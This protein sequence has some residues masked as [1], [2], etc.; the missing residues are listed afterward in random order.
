MSRFSRVPTAKCRFCEKAIATKAAAFERSLRCR[1]FGGVLNG[2]NLSLDSCG[3]VPVEP[4][5]QVILS[6]N[7][8]ISF[9]GFPP[10][11]TLTRLEMDDTEIQDF[12]NFPLLKNL[13]VISLRNTPVMANPHARTALIII[14]APC[15]RVVNHEV[16]TSF[17]RKFAN[18]YPPEC[19]AMIRAGWMPTVPPPRKEELAAINMAYAEKRAPKIL[20]KV[21]PRK[22]AEQK[23]RLHSDVIIEAQQK[24]DDELRALEQEIDDLTRDVAS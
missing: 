7:P 2:R 24:Q 23:V 5:H 8:I 4:V 17:E 9:F 19:A 11:P 22:K 20:A 6:G 3:F 1:I 13:E 15:L 16:I 14:C 10:I 21:L 18:M 12:R